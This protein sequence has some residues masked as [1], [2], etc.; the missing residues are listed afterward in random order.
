MEPDEAAPGN[1]GKNRRLGRVNVLTGMM[2]VPGVVV[3]VPSLSKD[4]MGQ[5]EQD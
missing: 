2:G 1:H 3:D 5:R 4:G